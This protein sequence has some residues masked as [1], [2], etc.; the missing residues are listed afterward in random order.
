MTSNFV[1]SLKT[2]FHLNHVGYKVQ[3]LKEI[4]AHKNAFI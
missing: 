1:V 3:E 4:L 2:F